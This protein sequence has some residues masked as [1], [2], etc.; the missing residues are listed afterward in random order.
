MGKEEKETINYEKKQSMS[1]SASVD[2][3]IGRTGLA[4]NNHTNA[5]KHNKT[6]C[7]DNSGSSHSVNSK[8]TASIGIQ[9]NLMKSS[10]S[11][12]LHRKPNS[13]EKII[14]TMEIDIEQEI[15]EKCPKISEKKERKISS[16]INVD[17]P[18]SRKTSSTSTN[19]NNRKESIGA[20]THDS[21]LGDGDSDEKPN[22][23]WRE[24]LAKF[25]SARPQR[26][27]KLIGTFDKSGNEVSAYERSNT[28]NDLA[29]LK[30][31]RRGS[32]Q[33]Q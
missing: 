12:N 2:A 4:Q 20:F 13:N 26:V 33:I 6:G 19:N 23:S 21:T 28:Q 11:P 31:K 15:A 7:S 32:L 16:S 14:E 24:D 9:V 17:S 18:V 27:S 3:D 5:T 1:R 22:Y 29:A 10:S 8:E 30:R 25:Q